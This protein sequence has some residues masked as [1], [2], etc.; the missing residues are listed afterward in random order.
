M[1]TYLKKFMDLPLGYKL[2]HEIQGE[3]LSKADYSLFIRGKDDF[4]VVLLVYVDDIII[5]GANKL[6]WTLPLTE[7]LHALKLIEDTGLLGAKPN[8]T[9][10]DPTAKLSISNEDILHDATPYRRLIGKLLYLTISRLNITFAV[11]KPS[12]FMTKPTL[13]HMN[14]TNYLVSYL[15]GSFGKGIMLPKVKD[16]SISTFTDANWSS[17]PD[18]RRSV[19]GFCVFIGNSLVSWKFKKQPTV[20]RTSVEAKYRALAVT[21]CEVIWLRSLLNEL[22][23]KVTYPT[24]LLCDN[25][26]A[27]FQIISCFMSEPNTSSWTA[28]LFGIE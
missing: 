10:M 26:A 23:I 24:F 22:Q 15:K 17:C 28:I 9:L 21:T 16:F 14:A 25:Q 18:T 19:T 6:I 5:T 8:S 20:A 4:F 3:K 11:H 2:Q 7:T 27:I 12:Q 13:S 1:E